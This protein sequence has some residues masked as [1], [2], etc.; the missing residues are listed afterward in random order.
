MNKL[1]LTRN[2]FRVENGRMGIPT[3]IYE[4]DRVLYLHSR[5]DPVAEANQLIESW[6]FAPDTEQVVVV[7]LGLGYHI[8]ACLQR[9]DGLRRLVVVEA[10]S[11][12]IHMCNEVNPE[13][14]E[15]TRVQICHPE[16]EQALV[17]FVL[18]QDVNQ[19]VVHP[20][21]LT[22]FPYK[23]IRL[24]LQEMQVLN[25]SR[26]Y[27]APQLKQNWLENLA[28]LN[29]KCV[30]SG[31][32]NQLSS[33][34]GILLAAGPSLDDSLEKLCVDFP[35][36]AVTVAVSAVLKK[37]QKRQLV[38]DFVVHTDA[39]PDS[40]QHFAG[41][42]PEYQLPKLLVL[43]TS[44]PQIFRSYQGDKNWILQKGFES[45]QNYARKFNL[46]VFDT[47]GSVATLALSLL[48]YLGCD[49]IIFVGQDLAYIDGKTHADGV[50]N[51]LQTFDVSQNYKIE[52]LSVKGD[53]CQSTLSWS[54]FRHWI[55]WFIRTHPDRKYYNVS[56][57]AQIEGTDART[58]TDLSKNVCTK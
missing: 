55:E 44:H 42:E 39:S 32:K 16:D 19:L 48:W 3:L 2:G 12:V 29:P 31:H 1:V 46:D 4:Q 56:S 58:I 34:P 36:N 37:L 11:E 18:N 41:L 28:L 50:H 5:Y 57:G 22:V 52:T 25:H 54:V 15:D 7:G 9:F 47:G 43:P 14:F 49:P 8:Q 24:I 38:P 20:P 26:E 45:S 35:K 21:S 23:R 13:L 30:F 51:D 40:Y 17:Q 33:K 6:H 10:F 27:N 53:Y